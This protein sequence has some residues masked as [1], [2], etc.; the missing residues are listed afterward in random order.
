MKKN[1]FSVTNPEELNKHLQHTSPFT[2][3]IL[4][5]VTVL[6]LGFFVWSFLFKLPIKIVGD[7][8]ISGGQVT[9]NISKTDLN[10]LKAEQAVY[11]S[12][13]EGKI[14]SFDEDGQPV[15]SN[16]DLEDGTYTYKIVYNKRPI[17][18]LIGK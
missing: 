18:F 9:L 10:K 7:A 14:L 1:K 6:L 4:G 5:A 13:K 16:F 8:T 12:D 3:I 17:E 11:V 2:W 15:V